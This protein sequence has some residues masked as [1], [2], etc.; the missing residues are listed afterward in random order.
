LRPVLPRNAIC[1]DPER[2]S[3]NQSKSQ[4]IATHATTLCTSASEI[5]VLDFFCADAR[6]LA[7]VIGT[8]PRPVAARFPAESKGRPHH[9][10]GVGAGKAFSGNSNG[11]KRLAAFFS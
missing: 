5:A 10:P 9:S 1:T 7:R 11:A 8:A 3:A 2:A 6:L 4:P